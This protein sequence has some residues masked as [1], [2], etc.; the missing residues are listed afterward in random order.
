MKTIR[1]VGDVLRLFTAETPEHSLSGL[2]RALGAS[3]SGTFDVAD[4]LTEIGLLARVGRGRYRLGPLVATLNAV[5]EDTA[6]VAEAAREVMDR[7]AGEYGETLHLTQQDDGRLLV[8]ATRIGRRTLTV[9]RDALT[10]GL[11]LHESAPGCLHLAEMEPAQREAYWRRADAAARRVPM[12]S[13]EAL[14]QM[15]RE[16]YAAGPLARDD[17]VVFTAGAIRNH[18][19]LSAGVLSIAVPASRHAREPRAFRS[20]TLRAAGDVSRSLGYTG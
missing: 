7:L 17:D 8:L 6:P 12:P 15:R 16:G 5:L 4:G 13:D 2:A 11:A 20:V 9:T 10:P 18:A 19:G 1:K 3:P 14:A